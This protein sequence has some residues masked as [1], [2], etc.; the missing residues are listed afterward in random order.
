MKNLGPA[1]IRDREI[2]DTACM[3][4]ARAGQWDLADYLSQ[5]KANIYCF[6]SS[7]LQFPR[8]PQPS[9]FILIETTRFHHPFSA[10]ASIRSAR[11]LDA[12]ELLILTNILG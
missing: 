2:V 9:S 5:S 12:I 11:A 4:A 1:Q 8:P 10:R 6:P 7:H 3:C